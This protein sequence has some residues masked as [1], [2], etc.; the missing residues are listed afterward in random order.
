MNNPAEIN[1]SRRLRKKLFMDEFSI[2]GFGFTCELA[3]DNEADLDN[4]FDEFIK[5]VES[6]DLHIAGGSDDK[7]FDGFITSI[8][9]YESATEEDRTAIQD[10]LTAREKVSE[11]VLGKLQDPADIDE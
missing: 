8:G 4:F 1:R 9:R 6:N 11:V 7:Y 10:W 2:L 5:F 3:F